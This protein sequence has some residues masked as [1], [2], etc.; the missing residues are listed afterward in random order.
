MLREKQV[1]RRV[2]EWLGPYTVVTH[3][4]SSKNVVV[5]KNS[6]SAHKNF[7]LTQVKPFLRPKNAA[8]TFRDALHASLTKYAN[9]RE[10]PSNVTSPKDSIYYS[11]EQDR[12]THERIPDTRSS[13]KNTDEND[14]KPWT[15]VTEVIG[16]DEPRA[17]SPEMHEA[18][19][20]GVRVL[21]RRGTF[22]VTLK[23]G[24]PMALMLSLPNLYLQ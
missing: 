1:E 16:K 19:M 7:S 6:D 10:G 4:I 3:V 2:G 15:H 18:D 5:R 22:Y 11:Y 13:A 20:K 24:F 14:K 21:L 8:T 23:K 17:M 12:I 9:P